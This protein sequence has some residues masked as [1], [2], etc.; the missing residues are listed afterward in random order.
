MGSFKRTFSLLDSA[1][2]SFKPGIALIVLPTKSSSV[3]NQNFFTSNFGH[4]GL[5][6]PAKI[7]KKSFEFLADF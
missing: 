5:V 2:Q 1:K 4:Q 3:V 7:P 6:L